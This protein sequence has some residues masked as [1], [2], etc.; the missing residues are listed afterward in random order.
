MSAIF[1]PKELAGRFKEFNFPSKQIKK[2]TVNVRQR[3]P[4]FHIDMSG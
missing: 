1:F 3:S 2:K 4:N